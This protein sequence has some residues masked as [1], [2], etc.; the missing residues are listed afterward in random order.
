MSQKRQL[1]DTPHQRRVDEY[2]ATK[3][4]VHRITRWLGADIDRREIAVGY[5]G[6]LNRWNQVRNGDE[7]REFLRQHRPTRVDLGAVY[8]DPPSEMRNEG[9]PESRPLTFDLDLP[10]YDD[11]RTCCQG[12]ES[13]QRCWK[14]IHVAVQIIDDLLSTLGFKHLLWVYSGNKG[15]HCWVCDPRACALD[16][17][18]REAMF[19]FL[20]TPRDHPALDE[21]FPQIQ[22]EQGLTGTD[23]LS[24]W[25]RLD[26]PI[27]TQIKHLLKS[28]FCAHPK[29]GRICVP[30]D[31]SE[32]LDVS[33]VPTVD[34]CELDL[35]FFDGFL[36][37]LD[38]AETLRDPFYFD[39]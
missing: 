15:V 1:E 27:T 6:G 14:L 33:L 7:L 23:H 24:I 28:P 31:P 36:D 16:N 19:D 2:F 25:P 37:Q 4:P 39:T 22:A 26:R 21:F 10:D 5:P 18:G 34:D 38:R 13:C 32:P 8:A 12:G 17:T 11:V 3:F 30:F 9:V 35:S 29:T 20:A